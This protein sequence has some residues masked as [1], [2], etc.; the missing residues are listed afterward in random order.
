MLQLLSYHLYSELFESF[1][2]TEM[3]MSVFCTAVT[4]YKFLA[5]DHS[6]P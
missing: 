3:H 4:G 6:R 1:Q 5:A 2:H